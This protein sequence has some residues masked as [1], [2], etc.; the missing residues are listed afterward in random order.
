MVADG[1]SRDG[2]YWRALPTGREKRQKCMIVKYLRTLKGLTES[3][4]A[5]GVFAVPREY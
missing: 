2:W 3:L 1:G 5:G 4:P